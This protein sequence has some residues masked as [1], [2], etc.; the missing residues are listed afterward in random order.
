MDSQKVL[1]QVNTDSS[2]SVNAQL[3]TRYDP[4]NTYP[5]CAAF[6]DDLTEVYNNFYSIKNTKYPA[7]VG[8]AN[9]A[10]AS[11]TAYKTQVS[12]VFTKFQTAL[13]NLSGALDPVIDPDYGLIAGFNC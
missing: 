7:I 3:H 12:T 13:L 2:G 11:I 4:G 9:T 6:S 10:D 8:R 5:D 1:V